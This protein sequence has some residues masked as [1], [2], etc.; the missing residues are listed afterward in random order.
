VSA[1]SCKN[2]PRAENLLYRATAFNALWGGKQ[3]IIELCGFTLLNSLDTSKFKGSLS[4]NGATPLY[5]ATLD[6]V[7]ALY[8]YGKTLYQKR[9][10]CNGILFVIT[11]GEDNASEVG[12]TPS[13]IKDMI[14]KII[15]E[16]ILE[17]LRTILIGVNDG[18][19]SLKNYLDTFKQDA[20]IDEYISIGNVTSGKLAKLAQFVSQSVSS[21]S[22]AL[23][24]GGSSQP[25]NFTF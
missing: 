1:E 10:V 4:P 6:A 24:T 11:D 18:I 5:S 7:D 13:V 14:Q 9:M 12:H 3:N 22:Q 21:Q 17:S 20:E 19:D 15:N 16:G 25:I 2:S 23:G 8:D